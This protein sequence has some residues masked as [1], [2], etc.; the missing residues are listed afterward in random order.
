M[1]DVAPNEEL[2]RLRAAN[3]ELER[4]MARRVRLRGAL[5][6][7][8][9]V[10][11]CGLAVLSLVAVWLR[12]TMLNTDRYVSTVTPIAAN[13]GVQ[14]A[15]AKKLETAIYTRVDF[16]SEKWTDQPLLQDHATAMRG[17]ADRYR[18]RLRMLL[19]LGALE[20]GG[21]VTRVAL[22]MGYAS[23]SAFIAAFRRSFGATPREM[24]SR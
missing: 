2:E 17:P 8:L 7:L 13:P 20:G 14:D 4:R 6:A 22:D 12:A 9:L 23:T 10:L 24:F 15:V 1:T 3:A 21:S 11:G 18:S 16:A 5:S 19:S